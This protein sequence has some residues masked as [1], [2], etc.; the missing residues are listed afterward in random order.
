[1]VNW[2]LE[3][4]IVTFKTLYFCLESILKHIVSLVYV[5]RKDVKGEIVLV[6]GAGSG[7][8]RLMT[9]RFADL[10]ARVVLLDVNEE[11]IEKV[12]REVKS[13]GGDPHVYQCDLSSREEIYKV[14]AKIKKEVGDVTFL[15]NNAGV[16]S[17]KKFMDL[18]DD[19]VDM[20]FKVNTIA[21]FWVSYCMG[22]LIQ[23][24]PNT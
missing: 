14:A 12:A 16:V 4:F 1:M 7:I 20:T 17:G 10:G 2:I 22:L 18:P 13:K 24:E 19:K 21:H 3:S 6:T 15:V 5:P 23:L 9:L 11:S 8:G